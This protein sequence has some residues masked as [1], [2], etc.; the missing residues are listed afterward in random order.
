MGNLRSKLEGPR[1]GP[2]RFIIVILFILT[3]LAQAQTTGALY[4]TSP[5]KGAQVEGRLVTI[6][7][8]LM[9]GISVNGMPKFRVQL[10][11][12]PPVLTSD[13]ECILN[14]LSPGWH[15]VT[16]WLLDA[17]DTPI[18]GAQDQVQFNVEPYGP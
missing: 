1:C 12:Q 9:P 3:A 8:E 18:Y 4:I 15:T 5:A 11:R 17:N 6:Q 2:G 16:V 7:Y 13:R 14:W 10:D